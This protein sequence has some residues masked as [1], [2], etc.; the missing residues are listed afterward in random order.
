[1]FSMEV[2][3]KLIEVINALLNC[4]FQFSDS[5]PFYFPS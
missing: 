3:M 1:M 4:I 2:T 5:E